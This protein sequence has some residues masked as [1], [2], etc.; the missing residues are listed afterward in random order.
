[1]AHSRRHSK[2]ESTSRETKLLDKEIYELEHLTAL[3]R[4]KYV[5]PILLHPQGDDD[6]LE[7]HYSRAEKVLS[8]KG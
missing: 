2:S 1:M 3:Q 4:V 5:Q 6:L 8:A 7:Q